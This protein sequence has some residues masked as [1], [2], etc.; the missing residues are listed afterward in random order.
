MVSNRSSLFK[1]LLEAFY[2]ASG[3]LSQTPSGISA[4]G[5]TQLTAFFDFSPSDRIFKI[6]MGKRGK[7]KRRVYFSFQT[8]REVF[9]SGFV[10]ERFR[11]KSENILRSI[12][13]KSGY[14]AVDTTSYMRITVHCDIL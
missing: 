11:K 5:K 13:M 9:T 7:R 8:K 1:R 12:Q 3:D 2:S 6:D 14:H 10:F 4:T